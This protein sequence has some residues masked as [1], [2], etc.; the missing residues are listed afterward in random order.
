MKALKGILK[1]QLLTD[2]DRMEITRLEQEAEGKVMMGLCPGTNVGITEALKRR[3]IFACI[4]DDTMV[5]PSSSYIKLVC[6]EDVIGQDIYDE[7][8][9]ERMKS[10]GNIVAGNL[11][12]YRNKIK[13]LKERREEM[14]VQMLPMQI[15]ELTACGAV[16][17]SPSPPTDLYLKNRLGQSTEDSRLGSIIVGID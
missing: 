3:R 9:L 17:A 8:E 10:E 1:V 16:V 15:Q 6:G 13:V 7:S 4:T 5:W 2:E 14:R 11:V 12:F